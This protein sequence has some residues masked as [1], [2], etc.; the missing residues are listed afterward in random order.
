MK[1]RIKVQLIASIPYSGHVTFFSFPVDSDF[2]AKELL[3]VVGDGTTERSEKIEVLIHQEIFLLQISSSLFFSLPDL[4]VVHLESHGV[5][6]N[7]LFRPLNGN[8]LGKVHRINS[9]SGIRSSEIKYSQ[10]I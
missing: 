4:L 9:F 6:R 8:D 5:F 7:F 2:V 3:L 1:C 10:E